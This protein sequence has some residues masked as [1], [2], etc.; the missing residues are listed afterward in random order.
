MDALLWEAVAKPRFLTF[1]MSIFGG[2]A[3][4]LAVIGVY[5]VVSVSVAQRTRELG[6][7][8]ALGARPAGVQGMV[9]RQGMLLV[10]AGIGAGLAGALALNAALS[11]VLATVLY[12]TSA[13]DPMVAL[14][15][16]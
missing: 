15:A 16:D 3:L 13:V 12:E 2:L 1:V 6:I 10:A 14:R 5:S 8:M 11:H 7:R 4:L 9:V